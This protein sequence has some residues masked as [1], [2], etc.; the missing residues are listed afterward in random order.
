MQEGTGFV[1][2]ET[3]R[4]EAASLNAHWDGN[5]NVRLANAGPVT[6][7][8]DDA[9]LDYTIS[10]FDG[11]GDATGLAVIDGRDA[12]NDNVQ[13]VEFIFFQASDPITTID[14]ITHILPY[15]PGSPDKLLGV[16][17]LD[18]PIEVN[19]PNQ[20]IAMTLRFNVEEQKWYAEVSS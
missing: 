5:L 14:T 18:V 11:Y 3:T 8:R 12:N 20:R 4:D 10:V 9:L 15:L 1:C 7:N 17:P 2:R 6:P 19:F 13:S 16:I